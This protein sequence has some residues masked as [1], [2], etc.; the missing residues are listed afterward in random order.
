MLREGQRGR[1][2]GRV[3]LPG[4]ESVTI[5]ERDRALRH[6]VGPSHR[7]GGAAV[8]TS[9]TITAALLAVIALSGCAADQPR[10]PAEPAQSSSAPSSST[11]EA[12]PA[13]TAEPTAEA[14]IPREAGVDGMI[15]RFS[16]GSTQVD[17]TIGPE[18]PTV[19]DFLS[20]LPTTIPMEEFAGREKIGYFDRELITEGSPG[21]DPVDGDL[22]YFSAWGNIGFYYN[23]EGIGYSDLTVHLGTYEATEAELSGLENGPVTIEVVQ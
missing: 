16:S 23:A 5:S 18:N 21:S 10:G 4:R 1:C 15:V 14:R 2:T 3:S 12:A 9:S 20:L 13:P 22:I 8:R 19:L 7:I 17:V 6:S 11:A